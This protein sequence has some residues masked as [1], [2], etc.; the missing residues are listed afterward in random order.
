MSM[1]RD[2]DFSYSCMYL[3][4]SRWLIGQGAC[5]YGSCVGAQG[6]RYIG[7]VM[8]VHDHDNVMGCR[9][10]IELYHVVEVNCRG[11]LKLLQGSQQVG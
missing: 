7:C 9:Q 6:E 10:R 8:Y 2:P 11:H 1:R 4:T 5:I 3:S